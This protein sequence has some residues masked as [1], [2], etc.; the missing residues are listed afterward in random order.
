MYLLSSSDLHYV[1]G[2]I[3][4]LDFSSMNVYALLG[5]RYV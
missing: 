5:F 1:G 3:V 4:L 2:G